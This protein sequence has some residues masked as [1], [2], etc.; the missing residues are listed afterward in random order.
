M[1][2]LMWVATLVLA[3]V[4]LA[5]MATGAHAVTVSTLVFEDPPGAQ[6]GGNGGNPTE[7]QLDDI[8]AANESALGIDIQAIGKY[9]PSTDLFEAAAGTNFGGTFL[10][11]TCNTPGTD[12][13]SGFTIDFDFSGLAVD[14]QIV[15]IV[16][17][18]AGPQMP[19]G[20][21]S[22]SGPQDLQ[23][24]PLDDLQS[25]FISASEYAEY[26]L[27]ANALCGGGCNHGRFFNPGISH[28]YIFGTPVTANVPEPATLV[29]LGSGLVGLAIVART[30][31]GR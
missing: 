19:F 4:S 5:V 14:W 23:A 7:G 26:V 24:G 30:K 11:F 13:N 16:V 9:T 25:A 17:K 29:L 1:K 22:L 15:K 31:M 12:C 20:A 8:I 21:F 3:V 18:A 27:A 2:R 6:F 10:S 28:I